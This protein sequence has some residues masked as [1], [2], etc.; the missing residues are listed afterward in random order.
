[1][2]GVAPSTPEKQNTD[3]SFADMLNQK[4]NLDSVQEIVKSKELS[5]SKKMIMLAQLGY[6]MEDAKK[7]VE[8][9]KVKEEAPPEG[10]FLN[11]SNAPPVKK[12]KKTKMKF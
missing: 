6:S 9:F 1:M 4:T 2:N 5:K 7:L 11:S 8:T 12:T 10:I 3:T